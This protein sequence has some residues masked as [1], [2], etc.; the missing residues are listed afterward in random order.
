[1]ATG[2]EWFEE[3]AFWDMFA[4]V[5]F[6]AERWAEVPAVA[7]GIQS[8]SGFGPAGPGGQATQVVD[9]CCGSGR[10]AVELAVR[11]YQVTGVDI[12]A[13][14]LEAARESALDESV[15]LELVH[16]DVRRFVRPTNFN[17]ALNLYISFGYF[18]DPADDLLFARNAQT[19]L[20]PGGVFIIETLGRELAIRD[21]IPGE[22]FER[23]GWD[24]TTSF[25]AVD[26]WAGLRNHWTVTRG[27]ERFER[28]FVQ[29]LYSAANLKALLLKAGFTTVALYG[30]WDKSP[31]DDKAR[32]LIAVAGK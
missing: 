21:F 24:V 16:A 18:D 15:A 32:V 19:S 22:T 3:E 28:S 10:I 13:S 5:M 4:P 31:Y 11:G 23:G 25:E 7:D 26:S 17:L 27:T 29:R 1:M 9:L 12:T 30:E 20:V 14:Y 2:G 6:G 8:L